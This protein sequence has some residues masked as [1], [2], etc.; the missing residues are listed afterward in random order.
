MFGALPT[1]TVNSCKGHSLKLHP[2]LQPMLTEL[3]L[4]FNPCPVAINSSILIAVPFK[5]FKFHEK[6]YQLINCR[7]EITIK[8]IS[9]NNSPNWEIILT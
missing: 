3:N 9:G 2:Y 8:L 6:N 1:S 4:K 7:I 5:P